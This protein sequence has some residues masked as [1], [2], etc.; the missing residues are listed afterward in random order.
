[1]AGL[2]V[3]GA[4]AKDLYPGVRKW[5]GQDYADYKPEWKQLF[6]SET[7]SRGF[8]EYVQFT[9][10][11]LAA[12][13]REGAAVTYDDMKQGWVTR[14]VPVEYATGFVVSRIA[15][16]DGI[17]GVVAKKRA[18]HCSRSLHQTKETVGANL[19]NRAFNASYTMPDGVSVLNASHVAFTGGTFS[20]VLSTATD[21]SEA[22]LEQIC[23]DIAGATNDRGLKIRLLPDK[24]IV[25]YQLE[26]E[27]ER[28]LGSPY[29]V[30]TSDN[31]VNALRALG[32]FPGGA[33]M[34]HYLTDT[35][36]WFVRT[37]IKDDG[38]VMF[39]RE[40]ARF[41]MDNEFDTENAKYKAAERYVFG[42]GDPRSLYGTPGA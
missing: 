40:A 4:F 23:I 33:H 11:G 27:V 35:D 9:G 3:S 36:A 7:T 25:P 12:I 26:F 20:N 39:Q 34:C 32:K 19:Y 29:R 28:V 42:I 1:M 13:K 5:W 16:A 17:S 38:L 6:E 41:G 22:G 37:N 24:L 21:F 2:I 31:D 18:R 15:V 10:L 30:A 14:F 8:E